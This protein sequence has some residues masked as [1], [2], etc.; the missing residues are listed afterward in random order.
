VNWRLDGPGWEDKPKR[1]CLVTLL[2]AVVTLAVVGL[3]VLAAAWFLFSGPGPAKTETT[4][5]LRKGAGVREIAATLDRANVVAS[6]DLFK[7]AATISGD[8][9]RLK[10]GEYAFPAHASMS[11][12]LRKMAAGEVVRHFVTVPEGK[13]S[14]MAVAILNAEPALVGVVEVPPEGSILPDTYEVTRG[15]TRAAVLQRMRAARDAVLAELWPKRAPD[16]PVS[17]PEEAIILA[18]IVEKETGLRA[19]QPQVAAIFV[20]RLKKGMRLEADP[21]IIYAVSRG[22]PLGRGLRAS[23]LQLDSPYNT[24]LVYGL[25]P[26]PIANPGRLAI[27]SVLNPPKSDALYFVAN[28]TGGHAFAAT[29]EQHQKNVQRW[30][31]IE[32]AKK[33]GKPLPPPLPAP[34]G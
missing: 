19:E 22:E 24:Y 28:G 34:A 4:V 13:T 29:Y 6:A 14:A 9:R 7:L 11:E 15:E 27:Q 3:A 26:T 1:G 8:H 2:S 12:V 18:S 32:A 17:T 5:I 20:N 23:E 33:S 16:L 10:A 30:R 25:P 31:E 21:T